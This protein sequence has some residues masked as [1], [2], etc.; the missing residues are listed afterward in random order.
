TFKGILYH[1]GNQYEVTRFHELVCGELQER[2]VFSRQIDW[3]Q[4]W[5][6]VVNDLLFVYV[7]QNT[8]IGQRQLGTVQQEFEILLETSKA[9]TR[10]ALGQC[11]LAIDASGDG[12]P[13]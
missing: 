2:H 1:D 7:L 9:Q 11:M 12:G 10:L 8:G 3:Q 5:V 4:S 6:N 13:A